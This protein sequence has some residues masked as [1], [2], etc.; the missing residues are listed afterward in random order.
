VLA[1]VAYY[2]PIYRSVSRHPR[3]VDGCVEGNP[4]RRTLEDLHAA[5]WPLAEPALEAGK[6][7][8]LERYRRAPAARVATDAADVLTA[9]REERV[10]TLFV[11]AEPPIPGN[12]YN[13]DPAAADGEGESDTQ[14]V[15]DRAVTDAFQSGAAVYAVEPSA[16]GSSTDIAA[17]L[18]F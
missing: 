14:D 1:A 2:A 8:A 3:I 6:V 13:H 4:E 9:A 7:R 5:A 11:T 12:A 16:F 17:R 18:R 10:D 15:A